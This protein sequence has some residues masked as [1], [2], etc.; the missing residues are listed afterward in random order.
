MLETDAAHLITRDNLTNLSEIK[1]KQK[2]CIQA[3][4]LYQSSGEFLIKTTKRNVVEEIWRRW[5]RLNKSKSKPSN[6]FDGLVVNRR[7][8]SVSKLVCVR[9]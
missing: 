2:L 3:L 7:G 5:G 6:A 8:N 9:V 1:G 4:I